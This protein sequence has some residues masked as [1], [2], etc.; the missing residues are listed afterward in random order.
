MSR[1][2]T[3][4]VF[5]GTWMMR[6]YLTMLALAI[7]SGAVTLIGVTQA[8]P[9]D[10]QRPELRAW[11]QSLKSKS[12]QRCCDGGDAEHVEAE[13]DMAKGG[14]RVFLKNPQRPNENGQW[15]DVPDS[16]VVEQPNLNGIGMVWW[17]PSYGLDGKMTPAWRCFIPG[18]G[19]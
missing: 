19:G 8:Y 16:A 7:W 10:H 17:S 5:T 11:F 13:W 14:Y 2:G 6:F 15:Y 18:A 9:H 12:G 4:R 1:A 3:C